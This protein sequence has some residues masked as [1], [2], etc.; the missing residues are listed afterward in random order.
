MR[1]PAVVDLSA[2]MAPCTGSSMAKGCGIG[3]DGADGPIQ[4]LVGVIEGVATGVTRGVSIGSE[5]L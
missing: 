3:L 2:K 4:V 1:N 5:A